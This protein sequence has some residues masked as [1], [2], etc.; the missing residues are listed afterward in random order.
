MVS[1]R[2]PSAY[3]P[4]A[5]PLGQTGSRMF[6]YLD[7]PLST[8]RQESQ[9]VPQTVVIIIAFYF[10]SGTLRCMCIPRLS[11]DSVWLTGRS[12]PSTNSLRV[13]I[14]QR[15]TAAD[16]NAMLRF[17]LPKARVIKD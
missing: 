12:N 8:V 13:Y 3:Q 2:G 6:L 5:L 7:F 10:I 1:N 14:Q 16:A 11:D 4:N 9:L 17:P 15:D